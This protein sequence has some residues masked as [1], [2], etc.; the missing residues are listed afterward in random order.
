MTEYFVVSSIPYEGQVVNSFDD[1]KEAYSYIQTLSEDNFDYV[2]KGVV[3]KLVPTMVVIEEYD[4]LSETV[5]EEG[6]E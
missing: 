6:K 5:K 2:I 3:V 4:S 1:A